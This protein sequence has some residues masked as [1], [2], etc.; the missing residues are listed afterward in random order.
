MYNS[1]DDQNFVNVLILYSIQPTK[2]RVQVLRAVLTL[3]ESEFTGEQLLTHL[4]KD[5]ADF[6]YHTLFAS[7]NVFS[8]KGLLEKR[9]K[10][11]SNVGRPSLVFTVPLIVLLLFKVEYIK[12]KASL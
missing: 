12:I 3:S 11:S 6:Q 8:R 2:L 5:N 4:Q 1:K 9:P 10:R 7:L